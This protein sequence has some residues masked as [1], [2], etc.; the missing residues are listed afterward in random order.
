LF[1]FTFFS[2]VIFST[3]ILPC[4]ALKVGDSFEYKVSAAKCYFECNDT[5]Y[6]DYNLSEYVGK[7]IQINITSITDLQDKM[8]INVTETVNSQDYA[9]YSIVDYWASSSEGIKDYYE[10]HAGWFS[11]ETYVFEVPTLP[12]FEYPGLPVFASTS[13]AFYEG[14]MEDDDFSFTHKS[15][16]E[17]NHYFSIETNN[18]YFLEDVMLPSSIPWN[19]TGELK[20]SVEVNTAQGTVTKFYHRLFEEIHIGGN[21][22][23]LDLTLDFEDLTEYKDTVALDFQISE[24][25]LATFLLVVFSKNFKRRK[26]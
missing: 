8:M 20:I 17:K 14:L 12:V 15:Y 5:V 26:E 25:L 9:T 19:I 2:I 18:S 21:Y 22:S 10:R 11:P 7:N 6:I 13:K 1:F 4:N 16:S 24:W 3:T 23:I